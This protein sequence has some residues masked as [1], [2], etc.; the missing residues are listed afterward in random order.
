MATKALREIEFDG[1]KLYTC[2]NGCDESEL[3]LGR[4]QQS[5]MAIVGVPYK[6]LRCGQCKFGDNAG[7]NAG[8]R[9]A[10]LDMAEV[11]EVWNQKCAA[12]L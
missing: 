6:Y 7:D 3:E 1:K 10:K 9:Q 12:Y 2:P 11:I 4:D 5:F 8:D